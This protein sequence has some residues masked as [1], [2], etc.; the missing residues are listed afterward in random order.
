MP[1]HFGPDQPRAARYRQRAAEMR[2]N[3]ASVATKEL[4]MLLLERAALYDKI[5]ELAEREFP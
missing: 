1:D 3:A 5:A 2:S 4:R